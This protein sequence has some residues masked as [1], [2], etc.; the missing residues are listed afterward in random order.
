MKA[1][2]ERSRGLKKLLIDEIAD[3]EKI[4]NEDLASIFLMFLNNRSRRLRAL[5]DE[6]NKNEKTLKSCRFEL[7]DAKEFV[8]EKT[9]MMKWKTAVFESFDSWTEDLLNQSSVNRFE[10]DLSNE[11]NVEENAS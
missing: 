2:R 6:K 10:S 5:K 8:N 4:M 11:N 9:L 1:F 7:N 3:F